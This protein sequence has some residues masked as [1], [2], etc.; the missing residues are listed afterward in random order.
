MA[1][2]EGPLACP[3][4]DAPVA[5]GARRRLEVVQ[6]ADLLKCLRRMGDA[7]V[8]DK[9]ISLEVE[10]APDLT[11]LFVDRLQIEVVLR[12]LLA[13]AVESLMTSGR[14]SGHLRVLVERHE[15]VRVLSELDAPIR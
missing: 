11:P 6:P 3:R 13:N 9:A 15:H 7:A 10:N 2:G 14:S 1:S 4:C 5:L 12:N 8:A